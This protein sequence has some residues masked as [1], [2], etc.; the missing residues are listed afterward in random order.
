MEEWY[1]EV[2]EDLGWFVMKWHQARLK[3]SQFRQAATGEEKEVDQ[4]SPTKR[5][6]VSGVAVGRRKAR[7]GGSGVSKQWTGRTGGGS[8]KT[9]V[10]EAS[11]HIF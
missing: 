10:R 7:K 4:P 5:E 8:M 1:T 6:G 2:E 9:R 11:I 3:A